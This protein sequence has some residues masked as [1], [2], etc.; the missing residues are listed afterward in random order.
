MTL[1][2]EEFIEQLDELGFQRAKPNTTWPR[3]YCPNE[4]LT[5][6]ALGRLANGRSV[7]ADMIFI[8]TTLYDAPKSEPDDWVLLLETHRYVKNENYSRI[9]KFYVCGKEGTTRVR[10][11]PPHELVGSF[12]DALKFISELKVDVDLS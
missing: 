8:N 6:A 1:T 2:E 10:S 12:S 4:I 7:N 3:Y 11:I 9:V 5:D